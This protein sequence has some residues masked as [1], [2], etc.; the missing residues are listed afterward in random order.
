MSTPQSDAAGA[1]A[2]AGAPANSPAPDDKVLEWAKVLAAPLASVLV[3][4]VIGTLYTAWS[5]ER[6]AIET[7]E[8]L[9]AQLLTQRE[10]SDTL[11]R[12]DMFGVVIGHFLGDSKQRS[13]M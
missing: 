11:I 4:A 8:R 3:T 9:Y 6:D 12:K 7:N 13:D 1:G 2:C 10:Q 5:S